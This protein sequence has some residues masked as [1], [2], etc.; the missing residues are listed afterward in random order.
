MVESREELEYVIEGETLR[1]GLSWGNS[2]GGGEFQAAQMLSGEEPFALTIRRT[3]GGQVYLPTVFNQFAN[4]LPH[5]ID[6]QVR[7]DDASDSLIL[8]VEG[9]SPNSWPQEIA[10]SIS[11][12]HGSIHE[13]IELW[14]DPNENALLYEVDIHRETGE[15]FPDHQRSAERGHSVNDLWREHRPVH[16]Q[17]HGISFKGATAPDN[18]EDTNVANTEL[19][20]RLWCQIANNEHLQGPASESHSY[21][22]QRF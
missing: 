4:E 20:V 13:E 5:R 7:L 3:N 17:P 18:Y 21:R 12:P 10:M 19:V 15:A 1:V 9:N 8:N 16:Y 2:W 6:Q 14:Y 22:F 11:P